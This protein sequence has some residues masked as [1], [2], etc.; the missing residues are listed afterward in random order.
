MSNAL[1]VVSWFGK[2]HEPGI[3]QTNCAKNCIPWMPGGI[4]SPTAAVPNGVLDVE[5]P[6]TGRRLK[7]APKNGTPGVNDVTPSNRA[8]GLDAGAPR[9]ETV[10]VG[11]A[12]SGS[13][14]TS[15]VSGPAHHGVEAP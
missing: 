7:L 14:L 3:G 9:H 6:T 11:S 8:P 15:I 12:A 2:M 1:L 13:P 5:S 10:K 4:G